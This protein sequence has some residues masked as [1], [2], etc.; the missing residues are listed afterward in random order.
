MNVE[1]PNTALTGAGSTF[2]L[3]DLPMENRITNTPCIWR[4]KNICSNPG[5][6]IFHRIAQVSFNFNASK[7]KYL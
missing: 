3:K 2:G 4:R 7:K 1:S 6:S 5:V